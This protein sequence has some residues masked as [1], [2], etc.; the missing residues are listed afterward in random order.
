MAGTGWTLDTLLAF[1][2]SRIDGEHDLRTSEVLALR[3]LLEERYLTQTKALDA[4]FLAAEKAVTTALASAEKAVTKAEV[5]ATVRFAAVNEFRAQL[6]DQATT[7]MPRAEA[8]QRVAALAEKLDLLAARLDKTEGRS[9][10]LSAGWV[11]LVGGVALISTII[12]IFLA[13]KPG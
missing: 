12:G 9:T 2:T 7:F 1:L 6:A 13:L 10:G 3:G 4:A 8:E 11:F 5:A